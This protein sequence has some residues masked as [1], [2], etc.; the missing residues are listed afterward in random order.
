MPGDHIP[1]D[2]AGFA[3][4]TPFTEEGV[5]PDVV[6]NGMQANETAHFPDFIGIFDILQWMGKRG[7]VGPISEAVSATAPGVGVEHWVDGGGMT[8][9]P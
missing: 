9:A 8:K 2:D 7:G 6:G 1:G 4:R 5:Y 3:T